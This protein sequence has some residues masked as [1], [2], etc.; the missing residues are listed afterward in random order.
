M[1]AEKATFSFL[2]TP[3]GVG[4]I[5]LIRVVGTDARNV[6]D[7]VFRA[8][9]GRSL[10][11]GSISQDRLRYG[12]IVDGEDRV[13]DVLVSMP[14]H[15]NTTTIDIASHGG[16][17]VAERVLNL[18]E[19]FGAP[20]G[21]DEP[22][23]GMT[24][25]FAS[26]IAQD[27]V[28]A[29]AGAKSERAVKLVGSQQIR[30]AGEVKSILRLIDSDADAASER[31]RNLAATFPMADRLLRGAT[32]AIVGR[33]NSGKSTLFNQLVG[34]S[35]AVVSEL[36][37]T[38]R[39][40]VSQEIELAGV[41]ITLIDTA[42]MHR[43]ENNLESTAID[44]G[45]HIAASSDLT[46]IVLGEERAMQADFSQAVNTFANHARVIVARNKCDL[47]ESEGSSPASTCKT[48]GLINICDISALKGEGLEELGHAILGG[49]NLAEWDNAKPMLF[50]QR[51]VDIALNAASELPRNPKCAADL[52][53]RGFLEN[54]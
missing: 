32:V 48:E 20:L 7:Q 2:L 45:Q 6:V 11:D 26:P 8:K 34:R 29:I 4:A 49:L 13:D 43:T 46:V 50:A 10:V 1:T 23:V 22:D 52:L 19:K 14:P 31:L 24:W 27:A 16:T 54:R 21:E 9:S 17:R 47:F 35:A 3:S 42:G 37:G 51:Q 18:L 25:P 40:W 28:V 15:P 33:P 5:S 41:A 53:A 36:S 38:T 12:Y 39:D 30:L 44:V